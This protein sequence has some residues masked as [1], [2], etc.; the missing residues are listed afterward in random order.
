MNGVTRWRIGLGPVFAYERIAT[1]RRWQG[2]AL[3][4][5]FLLTLLAALFV[6]WDKASGAAAASS[7]IRFY[8]DLARDIFTGVV[9][10]ELVLVLLAAPAA[11]AGAI[12]LDRAR[13][14]LTHML[15]TDL[16]DAEIVLGKLAARLLPVLALLVCTLPMMELLTL[17]GGVDPSALA[18]GFVV[19]VS[20]AVA[21]CSLAL[22]FS[23][24]LRRTHEALLATYAV[25]GGWLLSWPIADA[26]AN[27][28][29]ALHGPG[30]LL[31]AGGR[32][33]GR[34]PFLHRGHRHGLAALDRGDRPQSS[35]GLHA[36][37]C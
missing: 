5:L 22:F 3:R 17:L 7:P 35:R 36:R 32:D 6:V 15:M 13:G 28:Q 4:S 37:A 12:C 18:S 11:T 26:R 8:A 10:S 33:S 2:Y 21:G 20:L 9:G 29:P 24:W 16:S 19:A 34:L 23:L 25:L 30:A 31:G 1:S 27:D 14:T